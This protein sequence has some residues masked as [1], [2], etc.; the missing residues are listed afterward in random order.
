MEGFAYTILADGKVQPYLQ[1]DY[2]SDINS[3]ELELQLTN[4][5]N[6]YKEFIYDGG[7]NLITQNIWSDNTKVLKY[8]NISYLYTLGN[9]STITVERVSDTFT[10]LKTFSYDGSNNLININITI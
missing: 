8:Y 1:P 2:S 6:R 3:I 7:G 4:V 9:L 10:Y 5:L